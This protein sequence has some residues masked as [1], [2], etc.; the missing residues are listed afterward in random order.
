MKHTDDAAAPV[1]TLRKRVKELRGR[2]GLTAVELADQL[3][4]L[5]VPWN[6]SI[7]A[8]FE[9]GRRP[10]VSVVEWL[11]LA[12]VL[13]VAPLHLLV[14]PDAQ[15]TDLYQVTPNRTAPVPAVREWIRGYYP[16]N[17]NAVQFER[18]TPRGETVSVSLGETGY[19]VTLDRSPASMRALETFIRDTQPG[20]KPDQEEGK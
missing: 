9:A 13:D 8:N 16:L 2:A 19:Q 12:Q 18:E 4:K 11:A 5:G 6:R 17:A 20:M 7:V 15:A 1:E 14:S 3:S 10:S